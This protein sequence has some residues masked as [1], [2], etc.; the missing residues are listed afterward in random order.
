[1]NTKVQNGI[2]AMRLNKITSSDDNQA[3]SFTMPSIC[4]L[5]DLTNEPYVQ[6]GP[7]VGLPKK[8][9]YSH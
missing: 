2:H 6:G 3:T 8:T 9:E 1:M 4:I 7:K 5:Y